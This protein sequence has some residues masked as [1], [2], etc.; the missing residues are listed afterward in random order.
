MSSYSDDRASSFWD[1]YLG[2]SA[3]T[4][5]LG[6]KLNQLHPPVDL[7]Q[8]R[9]QGSRELEAPDAMVEEIQRQLREMH[10]PAQ[11]PECKDAIFYDWRQDPYGGGWHFWN[12]HVESW[13]VMPRIQHPLDDVNLSI[14]GEAYSTDQGWVEGALATAEQ[15]LQ[16]QFGLQP[17]SWLK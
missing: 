14:C 4:T 12:P 2:E 9:P 5:Y 17:P 8:V 7:N 3:H 11:I 13:K 6:L 1:G 16:Q 15:V 10:Y